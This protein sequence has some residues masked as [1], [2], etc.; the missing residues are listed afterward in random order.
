MASILFK[1]VRMCNSKFKC[2][3]L[4][5][6]KLFLNF[7]LH[8]WIL[9][10]ILNILKETMIVIDN[11]FPKL[12]TVKIF[13]RKLPEE[14]CFRKGFGS[15]HVKASQMLAKFPWEPLYHVFLSFSVKLITKMSPPVSGEIL[16]L[17]VNTLTYDSKYPAEGCEN[18][19]LPIQMQL[20]GKPKSFS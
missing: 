12:Q 19:Q 1:V 15:Q 2:N 20:S 11:V 6:E 5:N 17:S 4:K 3:Y 10:E 7:L 9:H 18:L 13:V 8:F 16:G 14:H